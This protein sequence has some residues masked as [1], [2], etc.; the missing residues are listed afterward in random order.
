MLRSTRIPT[1]VSPWQL[2]PNNRL[3][4]TIRRII[5]YIIRNNIIRNTIRNI[6]HKD[7]ATQC[8]IQC[9]IH[10]QYIIQ[11]NAKLSTEYGFTSRCIH[12]TSSQG[13]QHYTPHVA[14]HPDVYYLKDVYRARKNIGRGLDFE[15]SPLILGVFLCSGI[16]S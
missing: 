8:K 2:K 1:T 11:C 14:L 6:I 9:I 15:G 16:Y 5:Q 4:Y 12:C 7:E 3:Y 10:A 13:Q